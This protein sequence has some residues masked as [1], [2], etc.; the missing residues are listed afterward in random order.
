MDKTI[1]IPVFNK[2]LQ[3]ILERETLKD[4]LLFILETELKAIKPGECLLYETDPHAPLWADIG[5]TILA[6]KIKG[7]RT[8]KEESRTYVYREK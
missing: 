7:L 8:I 6:G 3:K 1:G 4:T 5:L 2:E